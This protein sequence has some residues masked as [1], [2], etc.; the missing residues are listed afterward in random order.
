MSP[1]EHW[2]KIRQYRAVYT[3]FRSCFPIRHYLRK[4]ALRLKSLNIDL[5]VSECYFWSFVSLFYLD[6]FGLNDPRLIRIVIRTHYEP[7]IHTVT[8]LIRPGFNQVM[9]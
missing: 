3:I 7:G 1:L 2:N 8:I 5:N 9:T 4:I 6:Y